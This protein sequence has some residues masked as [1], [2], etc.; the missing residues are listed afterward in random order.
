MQTTFAIATVLILIALV[1]V[2]GNP[3]FFLPVAEGA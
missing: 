3:F 1:I 2:A